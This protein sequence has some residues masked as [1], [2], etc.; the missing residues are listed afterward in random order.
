[1]S[2][3]PA[4]VADGIMPTTVCNEC[5]SDCSHYELSFSPVFEVEIRYDL[6][7]Q[8]PENGQ[9]IITPPPTVFLLFAYRKIVSRVHVSR[10]DEARLSRSWGKDASVLLRFE[11]MYRMECVCRRSSVEGLQI[12]YQR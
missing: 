7:T 1:M 4:V 6:G 3:A 2:S 11:E 5:H 12:V 10:N 8:V 9:N